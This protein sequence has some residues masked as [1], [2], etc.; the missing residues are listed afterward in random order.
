MTDFVDADG[1]RSY[2]DS[3][4]IAPARQAGRIEFD[5]PV[6]EVG[7][8]LGKTG[9]INHVIT[10]IKAR[11]FLAAH[12]LQIAAIQGPP[13]GISTS[14]VIRYRFRSNSAQNGSSPTGMAALVAN[15]GVGKAAFERLGGGLRVWEDERASWGDKSTTWGDE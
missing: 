1:I 11:K 12:D 15:F 9:T 8:Q 3:H 6:G 2:V 4:Y 5:V 7:R 14:V 13:S 10:A